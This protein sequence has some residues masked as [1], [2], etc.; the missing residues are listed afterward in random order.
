MKLRIPTL[1]LAGLMAAQTLTACGGS[2]ST[3]T[4]APSVTEP[5]VT[6]YEFYHLLA[7]RSS[8]RIPLRRRRD[9]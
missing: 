6:T 1:M 2:A 3:D 9:R 8:I 5:E 4:T 7:S